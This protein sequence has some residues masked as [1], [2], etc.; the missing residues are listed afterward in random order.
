MGTEVGGTEIQS[1]D[2]ILPLARDRIRTWFRFRHP[3]R[4]DPL[5]DTTLGLEHFEL[6]MVSG[7]L[8]VDSGTSCY[9][10]CESARQG[11]NQCD[12]GPPA[13]CIPDLATHVAHF[14]LL[15]DLDQDPLAIPPL[16][17][18][19]GLFADGSPCGHL[20]C[21]P[22]GAAFQSQ[23]SDFDPSLWHLLLI[24]YRPDVDVGITA[25]LDGIELVTDQLTTL[26]PSLLT[27]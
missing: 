9:T 18:F 10:D 17:S 3:T 7:F 16:T 14:G 4:T 26:L 2:S 25:C 12:S 6:D 27:V 11:G 5:N 8:G 22:W 19:A 13:S 24:E 23:S 20:P 15:L 1:E 21:S